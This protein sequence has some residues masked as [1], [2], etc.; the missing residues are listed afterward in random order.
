MLSP[1]LESRRRSSYA[2]A[3]IE[4]NASMELDEKLVI[5]VP[6]SEETGNTRETIRIE[7]EWKPPRCGF[8]SSGGH[9]RY[10]REYGSNQCEKRVE[11]EVS[12]DSDVEDI[13]DETYQFMASSSKRANGSG[14]G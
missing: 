8:V 2:R 13:Y 1:S 10:S 11:Q 5:V 12:L 14:G 3:M 6:K 7:Y 9:V 4:I